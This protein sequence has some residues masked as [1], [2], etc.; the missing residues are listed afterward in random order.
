MQL[1][2]IADEYRELQQMLEDGEIDQQTFEDTV[3][4]I[5]EEFEQK[6]ESLAK[7]RSHLKADVNV[8]DAQSDEIKKEI[9]RLAH[10]KEALNNNVKRI[11]EYLENQMKRIAKTKFKTVLYSFTIQKN[12]PRLV[13]DDES[14]IPSQYRIP[15]PDKYDTS[16]IKEFL[17]TGGAMEWA[18]LE[19]T[20]G[21]RIR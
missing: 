19:Q 10:K 4:C 12:P 2:R 16:A 3:A 8:L 17:K 18:H 11:D 1:Y 13:L 14:K 5:D 9:L 6:A 21:L 7:I 20:E 15:Q